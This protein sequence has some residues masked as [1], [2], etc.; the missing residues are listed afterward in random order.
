VI[1]YR[2]FYNWSFILG[3][4]LLVKSAYLPCIITPMAGENSMSEIGSP[5]RRTRLQAD[6]SL[7]LVAIIWGSAFVAQ[8]IVAPHSSIFIFNGLRFLLG[9]L[10]LIPFAWRKGQRST[11]AP[12]LN[13]QTSPSVLLAGCLLLCGAS[14]QQAGLRYTTAA[15]AGFITGL[16]VVLIP[17]ILALFWRQAPRPAIWIAAIMAAAG[18]YL[19]STGGS[20]ALRIGDLLELAGALFWA[21][22]VIWIGRL[23]H[24][25]DIFHLAIGQYLVCG[26]V[27]L[28]LGLVLE[29]QLSQEIGGAAWAILYTGILSVGIGYTLQ[30]AGQRVA[31]PADAAI[32]LSCEAVFAALFGWLFLAEALNPTQLIGCGIMLT[33]MLLAQI[34]TL[35][36]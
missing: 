25:V 5:A 19:L 35:H 2:Q 23:V 24:R 8:R 10:V 36:R 7:L 14:L 29:P 1:K 21:L 9:A 34:N 4:L 12:G 6:L 33:G 13:R 20:L 30:A 3:L 11:A 17:I 31:P 18:L 27:S 16:Y 26:L 15:N 22:H 32:I 28:L